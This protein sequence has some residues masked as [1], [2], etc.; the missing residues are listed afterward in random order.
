MITDLVVTALLAALTALTS[1]LPPVPVPVASSTRFGELG[2]TL[3][4]FLPIVQIATAALA[5]LAVYAAMNL[6]NLGVW[7]Y[8]QFWGSN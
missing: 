6:W 7:V 1:L 8:H 2:Y 3:N 4:Q 5:C